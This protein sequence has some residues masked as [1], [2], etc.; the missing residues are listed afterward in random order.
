MEE[1]NVTKISLSTF[2]LILAIIAIVVMGVF[3]Y[4]LNNDK[5]AEV[6]KSTELQAQVNIL[7]G[8]VSDLQGKINNISET[9]NSNN[10]TENV[11]A[12]KSSI[13]SSKTIEGTFVPNGDFYT[14]AGGYKFDKNGNVE[15]YGNF[16]QYGNYTINE[17]TIKIVFTE[18]VEPQNF[19]RVKMQNT[20]EE[21]LKIVDDNTLMTLNGTNFSYLRDV[22]PT[23][24]RI[25]GTWIVKD[26]NSNNQYLKLNSDKTYNYEL[27]NMA[28]TE[29]RSEGK[30][31][32]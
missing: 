25:L 13:S 17:N 1:K 28:G 23:Y 9:I 29:M 7:N 21:S 4:K 32:I 31:Y 26:S 6:Q 11:T 15:A 20:Y 14:D 19:K 8:T 2:F 27:K 16:S 5:T 24:E 3:I 18:E 22:N 12:R 10:L 30:Y